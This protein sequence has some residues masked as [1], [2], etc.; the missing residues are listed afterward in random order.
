VHKSVR[1]GP[2]KGS[3]PGRVTHDVFLGIAAD[4]GIVGLLVFLSILGVAL[5]S[6]WRACSYRVN[7]PPALAALNAAYLVAIV[8]YLAAGVFLEL[9]YERYFW[10]ILA[11]ACCAVRLA[12]VAS[13]QT[14]VGNGSRA[15]GEGR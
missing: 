5:R 1:Y 3:S 8:S 15:S 13:A 10:L 6:L 12:G 7:V 9:A 11:L 14:P 4:L 2:S